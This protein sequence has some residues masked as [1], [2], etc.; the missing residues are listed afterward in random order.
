M[1]KMCWD[2]ALSGAIPSDSTLLI[3]GNS[4]K[5]AWAEGGGK[6]SAP[7]RHLLCSLPTQ[8]HYLKCP[9]DLWCG[10]NHTLVLSHSGDLGKD[11]MGCGCG[12]GGRL[13]GWPKGSASF[14]RLHIKVRAPLVVR[15][16]A[17]GQRWGCGAG[18]HSLPMSRSPCHQHLTGKSGIPGQSTKLELC[19]PPHTQPVF[20]LC[21][22]VFS[23]EP[24]SKVEYIV[25]G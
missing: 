11:L 23:K 25:K 5:A 9:I 20:L 1:Q 7:L 12:A 3:A 6:T 10:L 17:G 16:G 2:T 22:S 21:L 14:V 8:V 13:P 15:A 18:T 19:P 4:P 24:L